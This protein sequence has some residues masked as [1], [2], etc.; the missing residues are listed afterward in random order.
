[1]FQLQQMIYTLNSFLRFI[2]RELNDFEMITWVA[3]K[4]AQ[5]KVRLV[6]FA[7]TPSVSVRLP[8]E[9][10]IFEPIDGCTVDGFRVH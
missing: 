6:L 7:A 8:A 4:G 3:P 1:M 9:L 5:D 2:Q 10:F